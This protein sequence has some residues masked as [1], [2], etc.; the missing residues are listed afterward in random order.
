MNLIDENLIDIVPKSEQN[1]AGPKGWGWLIPD[2]LGL[3]DIEKAANIHDCH[4]FFIKFYWITCRG[5]KIFMSESESLEINNSDFWRTLYNKKTAI[6]YA[7]ETFY[8]NLKII[9]KEK[10]PTRFGYYMR[11]PIIWAY[12]KAVTK[13]G[14]YFV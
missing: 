14:R 7:N 9:N 2:K 5:R 12:Y 6:K 10:S 1:G 13:F 4:Y 11:K 3:V 8:Q